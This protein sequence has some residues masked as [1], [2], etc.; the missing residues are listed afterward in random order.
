MKEEY[1]ITVSGLVHR[2]ELGITLPHEHLLIDFSCRYSS[3]PDESSLG[4]QPAL[5]DRWRLLRYPAGYRSNLEG[6]SVDSAVR[7]ALWFKEAGGRTIVDLTGVGLSPD[8]KGL[9]QIADATGLNVIAASGLYID[10]SLPQWVRDATVEEL[11]D[12]IVADIERGGREGIRRGA[13]GEIAIE[14][15]T[16]LEMKCLR[17]GAKAQARTGAPCFLHVMSGILPQYRSMTDDIISIY[18]KEGGA[19]HKLVLC[20]QDGSGDDVSYQERLLKMG[21]WFEYD[22]FGSEGVFAFGDTY[23]Q[24]PTDSQRIAE[25]ATLIGRGF[26]GQL[27]ISQDVCYQTGKRSWG[28]HGLA[29]IL[30]SLLPRFEAGGIDRATVMRL[31]SDNPSRLF[32]YTTKSPP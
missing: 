25:V 29:H 15:A 21:L 19:L 2:S 3:A 17:A 4:S 13:I 1:A 27:L 22:T 7:E 24:L 26:L 28:G 14:T 6:K 20:H 8:V 9:R 5:A 31:M 30:D 11:T 23:I 18:V 12:H 10:S 32:S 16:E